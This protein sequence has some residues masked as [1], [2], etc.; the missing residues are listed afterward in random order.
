M[1][2]M[3]AR[4]MRLRRARP[5]DSEWLAMLLERISRRFGSRIDRDPGG[6]LALRLATPA[7]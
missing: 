4:N 6:A 5:A 1:V 7:H 3:Q 2:P